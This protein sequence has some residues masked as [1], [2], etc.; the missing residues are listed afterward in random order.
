MAEEADLTHYFRRDYSE[1]RREL[2]PVSQYVEQTAFYLHK[3]TGDSIEKCKRFIIEGL[4]NK[5][6]EGVRD[7]NVVFFKRRENGDRFREEI[8]LSGYIREVV[9]NHEIMAPSFTTY[10]HPSIKRSLISNYAAS[11]VKR[12]SVAKKAAQKAKAQ[13]NM[14]VFT[15]KDNEQTNKKLTNNSLSGAFNTSASPLCNPTAHSTLTSTTR[16]VASFGNAVNEKMVMGNRHYWSAEVAFYNVISI[17]SNFDHEE[18]EST[19]V[20]YG[21]V[22]PTAE[23]VMECITYSTDLYWKD[24]KKTAKIRALVETLTPLERAAFVYIGDLYHIRKHNP[25]MMRKFITALA[26]KDTTVCGD[27]LAEVKS[28]GEGVLNLA[29]HICYNEVKGK[30]K[31]Y[32]LINSEG[33]LSTVVSTSKHILNTLEEMKQFI[34]TFMLSKHVPASVAYI[35]NML[36]RCV[37]LSDTDSTCASYQDWVE[38]YFGES[39]FDA[40]AVAVSGSVMTLST[41]SIAHVLASLSANFGV[42]KAHLGTL[43]MK[44]EYFWTVMVPMNVSKHYFASAHIQEGNVHK[45]AEL[46][47]KGV[48]LKNSNTPPTINNDAKRII[49]E[50]IAAIEGGQRI[51]LEKLI[52]EVVTMENRVTHSLLAGELEFYRGGKIKEAAAYTKGE[53]ESPYL[54]HLLW[55]E[56]FESKYGPIPKPTY[57]VA[58]VA[59]ILDNKS[60]LKIWLDNMEDREF[61]AKMAEWMAKH[62]KTSFPTMYLSSNYLLSNGMIPEVKSIIDTD[63]IVVDLC[64]IYYILLESMSYYSN[65]K[66][67]SRRFKVI[68]PV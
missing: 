57:A 17:T 39:R 34:T 29:H 32:A 51:S 43:A 30:G 22:Y 14:T 6:F 68:H 55:E 40:A 23:D 24:L 25:E 16:T 31:D 4:K 64:N 65:V 19:I 8:S 61:A 5:K 62:N 3:Q 20:K 52:T 41:Q 56:V 1:Y 53:R 13:G 48:H 59:T 26:F 66:P 11:N 58:K 2:N 38:W 37:T 54:H 49:L 60:K 10:L 44:N 27:P 21:L 50:I 46:E 7:P 42:D 36:R 47:L 45:N 35:R 18:L 28:L 67:L 33:N 15:S 63:R 12:R 9:A